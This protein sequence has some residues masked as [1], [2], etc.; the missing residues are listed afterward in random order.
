[1]KRKHETFEQKKEGKLRQTDGGGDIGGG[2]MGLL[3]TVLEM[4]SAPNGTQRA[5][6]SQYGVRIEHP[7]FFFHQHQHRF[8]F[9][10]MREIVLG[11]Y[12]GFGLRGAGNMKGAA[13][14]GFRSAPHSFLHSYHSC[15]SLSCPT[16]LFIYFNGGCIRQCRTE[17][18]VFLEIW[19]ITLLNHGFGD[20]CSY[21]L[22][23]YCQKINET[24]SYT[25]MSYKWV[26]TRV[27]MR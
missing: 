3:E 24:F 21:Y 26:F 27:R 20:S 23:I 13:N 14:F 18:I 19:R 5:L 22:I 16:S 15:P 25:N 12:L 9:S 4:G 8:W 1:M 7:S 11:F 17:F 6:P 2:V 10:F